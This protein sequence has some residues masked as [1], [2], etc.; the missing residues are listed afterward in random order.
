MEPELLPKE[1]EDLSPFRCSTCFQQTLDLLKREFVGHGMLFL[2]SARRLTLKF[3][4][5]LF[6]YER[7][8]SKNGGSEPAIGNQL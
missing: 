2:L 7:A 1:I 8:P 4:N 5:V 6:V 3:S